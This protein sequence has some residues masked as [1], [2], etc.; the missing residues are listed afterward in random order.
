MEDV[1]RAVAYV[2]NQDDRQ[3]QKLQNLSDEEFLNCDFTRDLGISKINLSDIV[4]DLRRNFHI[5][6]PLDMFKVIANNTVRAF[7]E[8][9]NLCLEDVG[10]S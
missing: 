6:L 3:M 9:V 2:T 5:N 4:S 8:A 10:R 7:I 1:K